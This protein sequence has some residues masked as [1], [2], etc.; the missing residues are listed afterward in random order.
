MPAPTGQR[1]RLYAQPFGRQLWECTRKLSLSYWRMPAYN[2][3]R[4]WVTVAASF[5]YGLMY[6]QV[7]KMGLCMLC[8]GH[9]RI[10]HTQHQAVGVQ[11]GTITQFPAP[12]SKVQNI[13]GVLYSTVSVTGGG[14]GAVF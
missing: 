11:T 2:F 13:L 5:I 10:S 9:H 14:R 1:K 12:A 4:I 3:T 7:S 6:F 8:L